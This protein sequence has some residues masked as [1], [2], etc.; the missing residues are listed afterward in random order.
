MPGT[1]LLFDASSPLGVKVANA[2][3][4][5]KGGMDDSAILKWGLQKAA[6]VCSWDPAIRMIRHY[7]LFRG[8][9][10]GLTFKEKIKTLQSDWLKIMFM[11]H[12]RLGR[13]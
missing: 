10:R 4:I 2:I 9:R 12:V 1:E 6:D 3:V 7:P 5:K 8:M 11:V 13:S